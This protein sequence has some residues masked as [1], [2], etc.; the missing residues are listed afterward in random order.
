MGDPLGGHLVAG[1][2]DGVGAH[3]HGPAARRALELDVTAP[4]EIARF[5]APKGSIAIDGVSLTINT[6][7]G[8]D[9][10]GHPDPAHAGGDPPR[11]RCGSARASTSRP[12]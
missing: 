4:P 5:L 9:L 3:P 11:R 7:A 12:T 8:T 6:R 10:L 2:V 1:H